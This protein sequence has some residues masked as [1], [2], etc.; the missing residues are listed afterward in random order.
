M[1][2]MRVNKKMIILMKWLKNITIMMI[3]M[4]LNN[5]ETKT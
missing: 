3:K 2:S 4:I 5:N 1:G